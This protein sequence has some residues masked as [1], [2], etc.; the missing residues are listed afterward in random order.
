MSSNV[1]YPVGVK[2]VDIIEESH[3]VKTFIVDK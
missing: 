2:I 3:D 1:D